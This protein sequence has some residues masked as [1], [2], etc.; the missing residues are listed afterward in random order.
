ME[1][2]APDDWT[3]R[4]VAPAA[5]HGPASNTSDGDPANAGIRREPELPEHEEIIP[6][7]PPPSQEFDFL[8][9]EPDVDAAKARAMRQRM[10]EAIARGARMLRTALGPAIARFLEDPAVVEVMLNPTGGSGSTG[11]PKGWPIRASGCRPPMASASSGWSPIMSAPRFM[12]GARAS[13]PSC[14]RPESGSR[15]C[16]RPS[17]PRRPS[18]SASPPSRCSR[19]TTMW[20][21]DHDRRQA[22]ALRGRRPA[23]TSSSRAAPRPA[24][25]R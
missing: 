12:P 14:P 8:D 16:C 24:R 19:S 6:P 18:P 22:E 10:P 13:R 3:S 20:R 4:V 2:S 9:D 17:S 21:R 7:P 5:G 15:G 23:P 1:T 11:S 25:P